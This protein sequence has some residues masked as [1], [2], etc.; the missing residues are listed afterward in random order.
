MNKLKSLVVVAGLVG[1]VGSSVAGLTNTVSKAYL[2]EHHC[3]TG[4]THTAAN[5]DI[6]TA[7]KL[8]KEDINPNSFSQG[9]LGTGLGAG[10]QFSIG[11]GFG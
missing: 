3:L 7:K 2:T 8:I 9:N 5:C 10:L 6:D 11:C 1:V 4:V